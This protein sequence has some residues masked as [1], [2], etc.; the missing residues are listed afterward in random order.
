MEFEYN[1]MSLHSDL[2]ELADK[3][4]ETLEP[5]GT[6]YVMVQFGTEHMLNN[7]DDVLAIWTANRAIADAIKNYQKGKHNGT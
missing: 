5:Q 3:Y 2:V 6:G 1:K 4:D 7:V